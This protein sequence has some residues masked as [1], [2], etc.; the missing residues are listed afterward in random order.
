MSPD[1]SVLP[2]TNGCKVA[3][4]LR[5]DSKRGAKPLGAS[6]AQARRPASISCA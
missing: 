2:G 5:L 6:S 3:A 4:Q 1:Q